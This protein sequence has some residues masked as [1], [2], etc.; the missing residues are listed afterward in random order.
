MTNSPVAISGQSCQKVAD[1]IISR[2]RTT[3]HSRGIPLTSAIGLNG[4]AV[5]VLL[6]TSAREFGLVMSMRRR[7]GFS[8]WTPGPKPTEAVG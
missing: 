4:M 8:Y 5:A 3:S 6:S 7:L 2:S 1:S